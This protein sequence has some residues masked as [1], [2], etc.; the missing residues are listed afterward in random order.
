MKPIRPDGES[1]EL[2]SKLSPAARLAS[3][4]RVLLLMNA[5][6]DGALVLVAIAVGVH[7]PATSWRVPLADDGVTSV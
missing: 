7:G 4:E 3:A 2:R 5:G 6:T 1:S